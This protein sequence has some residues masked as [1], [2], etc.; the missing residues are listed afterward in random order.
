L[1]LPRLLLHRKFGRLQSAS[2]P[3]PVGSPAEAA[4]ASIRDCRAD[5]SGAMPAGRLI[6]TDYGRIALCS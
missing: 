3:A 1:I 2:P 6:L 5:K 4:G